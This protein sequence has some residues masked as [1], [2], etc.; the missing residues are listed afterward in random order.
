MVAEVKDGPLKGEICTITKT[1]A[2]LGRSPDNTLSI[3]DPELSRR[4]SKIEFEES[5][6]KVGPRTTRGLCLPLT[7]CRPVLQYYLCDVGSTN[8]TY[9]QLVGPYSGSYKLTLR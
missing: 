8:G 3:S 9:I 4:H 7:S 6:G 2:T 5:D 1:G